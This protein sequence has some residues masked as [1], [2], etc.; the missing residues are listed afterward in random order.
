MKLAFAIATIAAAHQQAA[1]VLADCDFGSNY[2]SYYNGSDYCSFDIGIGII[3]DFSESNTTSSGD[4]NVTARTY[5]GK[6]AFWKMYDKNSTLQCYSDVPGETITTSYPNGSTFVDT[7]G[8][9][10][11]GVDPTDTVADGVPLSFPR[12]YYFQGGRM[13]KW[14]NNDGNGT[15][16]KAEGDITDLCEVLGGGAA[17]APTPTPP[18]SEAP[19]SGQ[20]ATVTII[21]CVAAAILNYF[22]S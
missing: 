4:T 9:F 12:L 15:I 2:T 14:I 22:F 18:T 20:M 10:S 21:P 6:M 17:P 7:T 8:D 5:R 11:Y 13:E 16:T 1:I 19:S 3:T